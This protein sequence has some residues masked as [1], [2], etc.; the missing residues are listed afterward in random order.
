MSSPKTQTKKE[1]EKKIC[2]AAKYAAKYAIMKPDELC[3]GVS[4]PHPESTL[5]V[6]LTITVDSSVNEMAFY[7]LRVA[8]LNG[9]YTPIPDYLGMILERALSRAS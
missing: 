5:P 1:K 3:N 4:L 6:V 8:R 2:I 9:A 7:A